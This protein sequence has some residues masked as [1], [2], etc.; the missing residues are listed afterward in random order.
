MGCE[1]HKK[2][3]KDQIFPLRTVR[4]EKVL[5]QTLR[6]KVHFKNHESVQQGG[7]LPRNAGGEPCSWPGGLT[8]SH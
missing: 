8:A 5:A 3:R 6:S 7:T 4:I 2:A 1:Q